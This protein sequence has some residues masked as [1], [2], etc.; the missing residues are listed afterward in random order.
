MT[1]L[2]S[3]DSKLNLPTYQIYIPYVKRQKRYGQDK[4]A[5]KILPFDLYTKGQSQRPYTV[6]SWFNVKYT[7]TRFVFQF[8]VNSEHNWTVSSVCHILIC[9]NM[10]FP[11]KQSLC[12]KKKT[13]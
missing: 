1:V 9:F 7:S 13:P 5:P 10:I 6:L 12:K 3:C 2:W 8:Q 11:F 4:D